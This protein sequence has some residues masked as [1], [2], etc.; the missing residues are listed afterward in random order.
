MLGSEPETPATDFESHS[1]YKAL[2]MPNVS[3]LWQL[4]LVAT[5][6]TTNADLWPLGGV[7]EG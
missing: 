5:T 6:A 1:A 7:L 4:T 2:G 3:P